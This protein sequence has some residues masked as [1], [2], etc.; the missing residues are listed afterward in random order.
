MEE[1]HKTKMDE[2]KLLQFFSLSKTTIGSSIKAR[3]TGTLTPSPNSK[4]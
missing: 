2:K 4:S 3:G 1:D